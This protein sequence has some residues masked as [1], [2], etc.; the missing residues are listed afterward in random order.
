MTLKMSLEG[1]IRMGEQYILYQIL[2]KILENNLSQPKAEKV[3][4]YDCVCGTGITTLEFQS[5]KKY[6]VSLG[7]TTSFT[8]GSKMAL[9]FETK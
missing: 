3:I 8:E 7:P 9:N 4:H 1:C 6:Q 2:K 5:W